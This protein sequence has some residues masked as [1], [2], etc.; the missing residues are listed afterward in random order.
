MPGAQKLRNVGAIHESPL[1][2]GALQRFT[3]LDTFENGVCL[4]ITGALPL[5]R[6]SGNVI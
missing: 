5:D 4:R 3:P 2:I 1:L 6:K